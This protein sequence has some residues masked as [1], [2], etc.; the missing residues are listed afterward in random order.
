M[1]LTI[2]S[3][4]FVEVFEKWL[5]TEEKLRQ[6]YYEAF[7]AVEDSPNIEVRAIEQEILEALV[8]V[9]LDN[10]EIH[11][12]IILASAIVVNGQLITSDSVISS[13]IAAKGLPPAIW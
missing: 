2:P 8:G 5:T 1:R 7:V 10:H 13:Y 4:V 12:K 9:Q 6:F 11:D 3:V